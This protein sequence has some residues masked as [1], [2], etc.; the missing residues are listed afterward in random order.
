[1]AVLVCHPHHVHI[2]VDQ[3]VNKVRPDIGGAFPWKNLFAGVRA[4]FASIVGLAGPA[5][6][7]RIVQRRDET[8]I[9]ASF[10]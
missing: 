5:T 2:V 4:P 3:V 7:A 9:G 10:R 6:V 8:D 1:M